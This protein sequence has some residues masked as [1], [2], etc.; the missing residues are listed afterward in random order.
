M[1]VYESIIQGLQ[2]AVAYAEGD[3]SGAKVYT[4]LDDHDNNTE[5]L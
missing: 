5:C 2:E 1:D 3:I 4:M